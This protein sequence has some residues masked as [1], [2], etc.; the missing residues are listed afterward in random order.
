MDYHSKSVLYQVIILGAG[1]SGISA[2]VE[3]IKRGIKPSEILILEK[4]GGVA[5]YD[6]YQVPQ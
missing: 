1:P 4:F 5:K 3:A 2:A 6:R